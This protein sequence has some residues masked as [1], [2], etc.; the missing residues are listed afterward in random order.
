MLLDASLGSTTKRRLGEV[1]LGPPVR[2]P[3]AMGCQ[4]GGLSTTYV[5]AVP[6]GELQLLPVV[7]AAVTPLSGAPHSR[8][9]RSAPTDHSSP[10]C[11]SA[12]SGQSPAAPHSAEAG[13]SLRLLT[14][15]PLRPRPARRHSPS[16]PPGT[17]FMPRGGEGR[18]AAEPQ[19]RDRLEK[20]K[21]KGKAAAGPLRSGLTR[22]RPPPSLRPRL[23]RARSAPASRENF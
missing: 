3:Q 8:P 17:A 15:Q 22:R 6:C 14:A 2:A 12:P 16:A 9:S 10:A 20:Q 4:N 23:R 19:R 11:R 13:P 18:P 5:V 21:G 7:T 1:A